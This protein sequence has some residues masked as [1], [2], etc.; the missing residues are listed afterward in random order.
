MTRNLTVDVLLSSD[1]G[2]EGQLFIVDEEKQWALSET[3][4]ECLESLKKVKELSLVLF[5][6]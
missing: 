6:A 3:N 4:R 1:E 5:L 2:K